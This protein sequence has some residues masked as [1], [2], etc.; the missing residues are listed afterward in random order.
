MSLSD[1]L[2]WTRAR[3][4][5]ELADELRAHLELAEADR[6]A[7]GESPGDAALN[8]RREFG[9][10][11]LVEEISRDEWGWFGT[12]SERL[13]Q[14]VRFALRTLRRAPGFASV[15]VLTIALGIGA[16]TAIF[17][18]VNATLWHPLP[19]PQPERLVR[20]EDDLAGVGARDVGMSVPEWQDLERS[21]VFE[22]V[23]PTWF[24]DN[25]LTGL[26][27][28]QRVGLLI[29]APN[30][31]A[32]LGVKPQLGVTF[33][34]GDATPGFNE[35]AVIS[36][37]LWKRAFGGDR[38]V[39]GRVVQLDSDSYRIVGVMPP[40]FQAPGRTRE[41]RSTEVWP[42]FGFTGAPLNP[43]TVH[44]RASLFPNA[45]ARLEP[46]L[47]I[48]EAQRRV[49]AL[50]GTL[51]RQ[52]PADYPPR[53][54]WRV[55]L[56]PL[57]DDVVGDVR[58]P[59]LFLFGAV[60]LV[61]LI[62]CANVANLLLARAT[63][64]S[65]EMA[66]RQALGGAPS[67]LTRQL[68]TESAVLSI[69]GGIVAV[70]M[71][72][73]AKP[74]LVRLVPDSVPRL[75]DISI[76]GGVLLFAFAVALIAGA[77]F[78]LAPAWHVR[79]LDV[80]RVLKQE[81]RSSTGG[82]EQNRTRRGLVVTE[83]ALSLVL[84]SAAGLLVHSFWDM[85]HAPLGFDAGS[86][87]VART[88][89][90]Y[91]NDPKEDLYAT[92]GDAA[93]FVREV[94]RRCKALPGVQEVALGSGAAVPLD[95]PQQDQTQLRVFIEHGAPQPDQPV[96]VAGSDVTP[97]YFHL[98][99]MQLL[100][101]RLL[102]EFDTDE[103][104]SVAVINE[105]MAK[106]LWPNED[107][108]GKRIKQRVNSSSRATPWTTVVGIVADARTESLAGAGVPH[109]YASLYQVEG[110]H[111]AIFLRG[112][113]ESSSIAREIRDQVQTVNAA[114]PVF[115]VTT[116]N[117]TVSASVAVRR[118]SMELIALFA[119]TAL[120]LAAL[121]IYGVIAYM[122]GERT[123]EIGVRL[124]L[125][126]QPGDV[127]RMVMRHGVRLAIAG[128]GLGLAGALVVSRAMAGLLVG[129]SP[130][131]PTTFA[132]AAAALTAVALA[133]CYLPARRAIRVDPIIALRD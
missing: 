2:P 46:G 62:G 9:N 50:V 57:R 106:T 92:V 120:F 108:L 5:R 70:A 11:G 43:A 73:A 105:T 17:S 3:R 26:A 110:K 35:Q 36:D 49:D 27:R 48:V 12:W 34:P 128:T 112:H 41:E 111:L 20:I 127:V 31:F 66:V 117:E 19:Y 104:P 6:I 8:A 37:G 90:P 54:D 24:D 30:Y 83:F 1:W 119:L 87:T 126:A 132:L 109:L 69:I 7:R 40:G 82:R 22:Y 91:P 102:D 60:M 80:N 130:N 59:L 115:G 113:V 51:R 14:D 23:S 67:R 103:S 55:R 85:L 58:Q 125:G 45:I 4:T 39:I 98:L 96:F 84:M 68:L 13:A 86:V 116:L 95:H 114:L 99:R 81:G 129:V 100:R 124:A 78:G 65:R 101:G 76:N 10:V 42:A 28:A 16:S 122:V 25:N 97:G 72:V 56:V 118:F 107:A 29:V 63:T 33:D 61:L 71:L 93:T 123:H 38:N 94:I 131:D 47:S 89:L 52:F 21:G 75:N 88:R 32:L 44:R 121:G 79:R 77:I 74:S 133:G 53:S 64:R 18:V 15:A